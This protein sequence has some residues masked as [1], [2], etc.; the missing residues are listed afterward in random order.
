MIEE[1]LETMKLNEL[2]M[3][4]LE[5]QIFLAIDKHAKLYFD[6]QALRENL[7]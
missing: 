4:N 1:D 5:S 6:L 3:Q 2:G 7:M